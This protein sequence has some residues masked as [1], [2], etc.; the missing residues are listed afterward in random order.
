[1]SNFVYL[2]TNNGCNWYKNN[3]CEPWKIKFNGTH[4][5]FFAIKNLSAL[6]IILQRDL[7]LV[8]KHSFEL[9]WRQSAIKALTIKTWITLNFTWNNK[10]NECTTILKECWWLVASIYFIYRLMLSK[11]LLFNCIFNIFCISLFSTTVSNCVFT[12]F[13]TSYMDVSSS[14]IA[15]KILHFGCVDCWI[16]I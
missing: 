5:I 3:L 9:C 15:R 8:K 16:Y 14:L 1:M 2:S 6:Y 12:K 11:Y 10:K 7:M 4:S 13:I